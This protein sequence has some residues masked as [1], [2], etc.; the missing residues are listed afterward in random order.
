MKILVGGSTGLVGE[1]LLRRLQHARHDVVRLVRGNGD[2][3]R[4]DARTYTFA[5]PSAL[6]DFDAVVHLG[7]ESIVGR[8]SPA[9]KQ[10]ILASRVHSTRALAEALAGLTD[11]PSC[12]IVASAIGYYGARGD[13]QLDEDSTAG[14]GFLADVVR[15]WEAAA[16]PAREAGIRVVHLRYG[17]LLSPAGGALKTMLPPFKLG[18]GGKVG[19]G[20]QYMSWASIDDAVGAVEHALHT[21]SLTGPVNVVS[22]TPCINLEFTR[23]LGRVLHRPTIFPVPAVAARLAFGEMADALLLASQRVQPARL[24]ASGYHFN[25]PDLE[26][27]LQR[28]LNK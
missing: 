19:S 13:E 20:E 8:W 23:A 5:D 21:S 10:R 25:D 1:A 7:G 3:V 2:G 24:T 11:K 12:L 26:P 9:K 17:M 22:P 27:A 15:A 14:T 4:W 16:D 18:L 6:A 28:L